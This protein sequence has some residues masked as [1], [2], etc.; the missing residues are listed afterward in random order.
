M[1]ALNPLAL[2]A[3]KLLR[4]QIHRNPLHIKEIVCSHLAVGQHLLPVLLRN[5]RMH[6]LRDC[7]R[8][9]LCGNPDSAAAAYIHERRRYL[10]PVAKLQRPFAQAAAGDLRSAA[11]RRAD[12]WYYRRLAPVFL[13]AWEA[14]RELESCSAYPCE[15]NLVLR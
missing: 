4:R 7:L 12:R 14:E 2:K 13:N 3:W 6:L 10:A 5:F 9:F 15:M 1:A 11:R 8:R